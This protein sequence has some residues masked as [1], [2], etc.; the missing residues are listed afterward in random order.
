MFEKATREKIRFNSTRGALSVEDLWDLPL[1]NGVI[2][3]DNIAKGLSKELRDNEESF[4][5]PKKKD[6]I[7]KLKFDVVRQII[8]VKLKE[9]EKKKKEA[10]DK[11]KYN[12]IV[13]VIAEKEVDELKEKSSKE[14][15][16]ELKKYKRV[17]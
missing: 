5:N 7:T 11:I 1:T 14:L 8:T 4:V 17:E 13:D 10:E 6:T 12:K 9:A 16:K 15:Q 2:N 3:L